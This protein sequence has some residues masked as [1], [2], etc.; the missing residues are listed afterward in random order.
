MWRGWAVPDRPRWDGTVS[1]TRAD[2]LIISAIQASSALLGRSAGNWSRGVR[3][4]LR[5]ECI[6]CG[7]CEPECPAEAI[8][9]D[10]EPGL[11]KWLELNAEYAKSWPNITVKRDAPADAKEFDG[12]P[13]KLDKFFSPSPGTGD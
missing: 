10:T 4:A 11:E 5:D 9:P 7:V 13:G 8:K 3:D 6:D 1:A 12:T 2:T